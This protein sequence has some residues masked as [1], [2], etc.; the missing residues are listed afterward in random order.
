MARCTAADEPSRRF[1]DGIGHL[2]R[3]DRFLFDFLIRLFI[4]WW[5]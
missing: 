5:Q 1:H 2:L 3:S 4:P